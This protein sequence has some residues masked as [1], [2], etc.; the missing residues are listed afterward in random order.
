MYTYTVPCHVMLCHA[1]H[2]VWC[3]MHMWC[4]MM[5]CHALPYHAMPYHMMQCHAMPLVQIEY[6]LS[7]Q[8]TRAALN[9]NRYCAIIKCQAKH[10]MEHRS[11][12]CRELKFVL[13]A[14]SRYRSIPN[15]RYIRWILLSIV[16]IWFESGV[17]KMVC[18]Y[19][20]QC[21]RILCTTG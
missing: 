15:I 18:V 10:N 4:Y 1:F 12:S 9:Y 21:T 7:L 5:P 11:Y 8:A 2:C 17:C 6:V 3:H 13:H 16:Y 14:Y 20:R 19:N